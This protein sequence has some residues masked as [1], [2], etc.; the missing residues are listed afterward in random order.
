MAPFAL[1]LGVCSLS[2]THLA[3]HLVEQQQYAGY[4]YGGSMTQGNI[5][6]NVP[7]T[8]QGEDDTNYFLFLL[9]RIG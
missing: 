3:A 7:M 6:L 9:G 5:L 8:R 4:V 2:H 1:F